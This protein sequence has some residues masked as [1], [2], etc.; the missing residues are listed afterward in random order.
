MHP[1]VDY[2]N[3][4][5][6][7]TPLSS[8]DL[9][10]HIP[11]NSSPFLNYCLL[12]LYRYILK[13]RQKIPDTYMY[14]YDLQRAMCHFIKAFSELRRNLLYTFDFNKIKEPIILLLYYLKN[15]GFAWSGISRKR[16]RDYI[17]INKSLSQKPQIQLYLKNSIL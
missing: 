7:L 4:F 8:L 16:A 2:W 13:S 1:V 12:R 14:L 17:K 15:L 6:N 3:S 9:S 10:I 5:W 11:V